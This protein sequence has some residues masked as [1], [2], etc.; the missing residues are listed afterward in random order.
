MILSKYLPLFLNK[1]ASKN[2]SEISYKLR[3]LAVYTQISNERSIIHSR[4]NSNSV[5]KD[6]IAKTQIN[7]SL[8]KT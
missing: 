8:A 2:F 5:M 4:L 6:C 7:Y 1:L 3:L